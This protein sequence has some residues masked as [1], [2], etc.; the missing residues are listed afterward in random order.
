MQSDTLVDSIQVNDTDT[1]AL[2]LAIELV[3]L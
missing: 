1:T 3:N 2:T